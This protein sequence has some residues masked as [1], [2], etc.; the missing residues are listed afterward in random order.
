MF[1]LVKKLRL[2][3]NPIRKLMH[4]QGN[5]HNRVEKLRHELD[6]VQ[7]ALDKNPTSSVLREEEAAYLTATSQRNQ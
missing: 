2:L 5:L 1:K 7:K 6:E 3:K 4:W